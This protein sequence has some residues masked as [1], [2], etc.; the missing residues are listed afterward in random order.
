MPGRNRSAVQNQA[1]NIQPRQRHHAGW[2][3]FVASHQNHQRVEHIAAR[4]KFDGIRNHFA[5][6]QRCPHSLRAHC[7][8]VGNGNGVELQR[9]ATGFADASFHVFSEFAQ[10]IVAWPD[11]NPGVRD[12]DQRLLEVGIVEADRLEHRARGRAPRLGRRQRIRTGRHAGCP[13]QRL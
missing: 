6:D 12:A 9:R 8:A 5:A 7:D 4:Y 10:V 13:F 2:N 1:R 11:F 3:R